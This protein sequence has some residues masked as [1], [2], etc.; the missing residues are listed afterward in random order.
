MKFKCFG[1]TDVGKKRDHNEDSFAILS[2]QGLFIVADGMGGHNAGEVA[3]AIAIET[4]VNFFKATQDDEDMTWPYKL[5]KNISLDANK[6][7]V[8][9]KFANKRIFH[10][11][12]SNA[13]YSGMGTTIVSMLFTPQNELYF[14]HVGD[15]RGYLFRNK[16][17]IQVTEDHSLVNEYLKAGQLT[18]EQAKTFPHKNVIMRALGMKDNVLVDVQK[19]DPKKGDIYLACSDGL[20]DMASDQEIEEILNQG[21]SLEEMTQKLIDKANANGGKDNISVILLNIL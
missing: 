1:Q 16:K 17:L 14:A 8:A 2:E 9:I 7:K 5:D 3:S 10:S 6:L 13:S 4:I 21:G 11:A 12:M 18:P 20:S 19:R 15:S